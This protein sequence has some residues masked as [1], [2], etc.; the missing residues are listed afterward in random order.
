MDTQLAVCVSGFLPRR[1]Q[2][3]IRAVL[4]NS[5]VLRRRVAAPDPGLFPLIADCL[6]RDADSSC[7]KANPLFPGTGAHVRGAGPQ[8][9]GHLWTESVCGPRDARAGAPL[10]GLQ[11]LTE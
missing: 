10:G 7:L 5:L 1:A 11:L 3:F 6:E 4:P 2:R 9:P 8:L